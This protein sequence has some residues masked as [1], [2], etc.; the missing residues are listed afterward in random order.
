MAAKKKAASAADAGKII[1]AF[2]LRDHVEGEGDDAVVFTEGQRLELEKLE[3][4][5]LAKLGICAAGVFVKMKTAVEG[6]RYSLKPHDNTWLAP[7]VYE[8]WKVAGYC[9]PTEDDPEVS[10]VLKAREESARDAVAQRDEAL[11][12]VALLSNRLRD[13]GLEV[14]AARDQAEKIR[15]MIEPEPDSGNV[16][17]DE[18]VALL[19]A[20]VA[21]IEMLPEQAE[22]DGAGDG[23]QPQTNLN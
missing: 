7:H 11:N 16:L 1:V 23:S 2:V 12:K 20:V 10:A 6:G 3:F 9:E 17:D 14:V 13:V 8:A 15:K 22:F 21:L 18:G 4:E 5:A 19:E